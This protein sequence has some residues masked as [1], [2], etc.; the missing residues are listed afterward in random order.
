MQQLKAK[1][2]SNFWITMAPEVAYVQGGITAYSSI[3]GAYLPI[4]YGLR[5]ELEFIHVQYY[6]CGG[7]TANDGNPYNEGT[8]DFIVAMSDMLL[9]GFTLGDGQTFPAL[10]QSQ[11]AFG[12]PAAQGAAS[13][14]YMNPTA[15]IPALDYLTKGTSFSGQYKLS[16]TFPNLRGIMTWSVNWD[17]TTSYAFGNTFSQYFCNTTDLCNPGT[18]INNEGSQN[19]SIRIFPDPVSD[20]IYFEKESAFESVNIYSSNGNLVMNIENFKGTEINIREL[21][22]GPY[23]ISFLDKEKISRQLIIKN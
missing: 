2:G 23:I 12:L 3:W 4:I 21:P 9:S 5:N 18:G 14:G 20:K 7:S 6:N 13:S 17:K 10:Q 16:G 19:N 22:A 11:V 1:Y 15:V 8:A